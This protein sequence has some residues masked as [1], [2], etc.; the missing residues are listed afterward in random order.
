MS[1]NTYTRYHRGVTK[2]RLKCADK[3]KKNPTL[4]E[5]RVMTILDSIG[6]KYEFNYLIKRYI[7]DF[8]LPDKKI[9]IELDGSQHK[10]SKQKDLL[11]DSWFWRNGFKVIRL[12]NSEVEKLPSLLD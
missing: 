12:W 1:T 11:R 8:Y 7:V 4:T 3:L 9:I 5:L 10:T 2:F 6:I